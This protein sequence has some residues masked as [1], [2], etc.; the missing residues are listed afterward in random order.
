MAAVIPHGRGRDD[1][2][3]LTKYFAKSSLRTMALSTAYA[4]LAAH[5]ALLDAKWMPEDEEQLLRTGVAVGIGR[6]K[7][8][9]R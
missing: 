1:I 6:N 5:E 8:N 4:V 2:L 3:D 9:K 7:D